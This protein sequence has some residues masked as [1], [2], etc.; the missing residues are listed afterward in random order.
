M[1]LCSQLKELWLRPGGLTGRELRNAG[2]GQ[3]GLDGRGKSKS[4]S[5]VCGWLTVISSERGRRGSSVRART[6]RQQVG[7]LWV[8]VLWERFWVCVSGGPGSKNRRRQVCRPAPFRQVEAGGDV[9]ASRAHLNRS[10]AV[11]EIVRQGSG[12]RKRS[13]AGSPKHPHTE[14]GGEGAEPANETETQEQGRS[15]RV[16]NAWGSRKTRPLS[17]GSCSCDVMSGVFPV[18]TFTRWSWI[19]GKRPGQLD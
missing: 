11:S 9:W 16:A 12:G 18:S 15:Q 6:A 14:T 19:A 2:T 4:D 5:C 1:S 13:C 8:G 7:G 17:K 3:S 10:T